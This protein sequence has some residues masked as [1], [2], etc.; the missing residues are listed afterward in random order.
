MFKGGGIQQKMEERPLSPRLSIYRWH[1]QAVASIAHR[2][3]GLLLV[4]AIP[5]YLCLLSGLTG[6]AASFES[7]MNV[8]QAPTSRLLVWLIGVALIYH[9]ANGIRF[10]C[11]DMGLGET[12]E[13]LRISARAVM[14]VAVVAA[15]VLVV[16]LL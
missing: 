7:T 16:V 15:V 4:L 3:S 10:L 9:L 12:R 2:A 11:L 5:F 1:P 6:D 8:L 13:M 14:A